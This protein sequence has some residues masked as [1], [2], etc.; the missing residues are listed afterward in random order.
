METFPESKFTCEENKPE[1]EESLEDKR[2]VEGEKI[3]VIILLLNN[4]IPSV[5]TF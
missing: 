5:A 4:E 3:V 2:N 1:S